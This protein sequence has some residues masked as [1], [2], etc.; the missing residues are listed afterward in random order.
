MM[1]RRL[2]TVVVLVVVLAFVVVAVAPAFAATPSGLV[3]HSRL[4][5]ATPAGGS[6]V[7]TA[8]EV[9]LAFNE[10]V[11]EQFVKVTVEGPDGA[12]VDGDP[13]V[14]GRE[15]TQPLAADLPAGK[16]TV[17]YR[18]V[19]ADGHPISG[20]VSFTTTASPSP[21]ASPSPT[22]SA[23]ASAPRRRP[24]PPRRPRPS[25]PSPPRATGG[26]A[27]GCGSSRAW[28]C[29]PR[30]SPSR[31]SGGCSAAPGRREGGRR[32]RRP[33]RPR[34]RTLATT[35]SPD[36][37]SLRRSAAANVFH[38]APLAQLAEQLT[39]NQRVRGSSP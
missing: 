8:E 22:R 12:E 1:S 16:H 7:D 14:D 27:P 5:K 10:E 18:V 38:R 32:G 23:S 36:R 25:T 35:P 21:S 4:L 19:S 15:V 33:E 2:A 34:R 3:Q 39:L 20:K 24:R 11:D 37:I 31:R 29:S 6:S 28:A 13:Q 17:T 9:V 26:R 30:C